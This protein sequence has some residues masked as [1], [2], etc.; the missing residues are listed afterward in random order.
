[1]NKQL[2]SPSYRP[3][4]DQIKVLITQSLIGGEW[5]PGEM[6]PSEFEL[7]ARY[8]VSQGTVRKAIDNLAAENILIRRQGKGTFVAT[9][10]ADVTKLRFL[11]LTSVTGDK[12]LLEN[13]FISCIKT[14]ADSYIS[15]I[16][17][18][19][20][21]AATIEVKRLLTFSGRPLIYDHI[22]V[23][24]ASFKGLNG[25][26]VEESKGS[27]YSMY[28]SQFGVRMIRAEEC[29]KAV[30]AEKEVASAL[31]LKEGYPLL[32]IERVS[33]T[34]GDKPMEWRLGLCLTD[35]HHYLSEL[36]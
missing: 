12:E 17:G 15:K 13:K 20:V 35:D 27:M 23:P 22:I 24:A 26:K 16:L 2:I 25:A 29:L 21:G 1:M 28:E 32:S 33:F 5:R 18:V 10:K 36:E 34:Y 31:G 7:A 30:A 9:H 19:K 8:K 6:I 4:Y 3:L 14:K 11:R